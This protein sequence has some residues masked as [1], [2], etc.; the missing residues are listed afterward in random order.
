MFHEKI[1]VQVKSKHY[2]T[3]DMY[4]SIY[5]VGYCCDPAKSSTYKIEGLIERLGQT[6]WTFNLR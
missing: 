6:E 2:V 1:P 4:M 5:L 3:K